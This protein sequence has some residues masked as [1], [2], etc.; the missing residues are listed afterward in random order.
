MQVPVNIYRSAMLTNGPIAFLRLA[1][2]AITRA[3][4]TTVKTEV[5]HGL[6]LPLK[7]VKTTKVSKTNGRVPASPK[8]KPHLEDLL[9]HIEIPTDYELPASYLEF[10]DP[11]FAK[12]LKWVVEKDP[13]LYPV[14]VHQNFQHF[15]RKESEESFSDDEIILKYWYALISSV[16]SQQ[17]SGMAAKSIEGKFRALFEDGKP[18]PAKTLSKSVEELR[19][20]GLSNQKLKYIT[21]ISEVFNDPNSNLSKIQFY[22]E[23]TVDQIIEELTLLK[24]IGVWSAKM[25]AL[26]TLNSLD[27]FAYDDLGIARGAAKY[28]IRR[29]KYLQKIKEEVNDNEELKRLLKRKSKFE[30]SK[31]KRDWV[32]YHDEYIK[33]LGLEF[34]PYQLVIMLV[35]WRL[36]STN[37]DVLENTGVR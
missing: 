36:G 4:S 15:K 23:N 7:V 6:G 33:H 30:S 13:S 2:M 35:F 5:S 28:L 21:H 14:I 22:K 18:T 29:P 34:S 26:F 10:H 16:I 9:G 1:T 31:G 19:S 12:G 27:V 3:K 17:I 24:G 20:A 37:V 8:K 11:E 25:F 32:P